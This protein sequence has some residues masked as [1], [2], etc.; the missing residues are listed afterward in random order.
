MD[1]A[2]RQAHTPLADHLLVT[3]GHFADEAVSVRLFRD[4]L[5]APAVRLLAAAGDVLGNSSGEQQVRLH[6]IANLRT[7]VLL[8]DYADVIAI[9]CQPA[10]GGRIEANDELSQRRLSRAA[11]ADDGDQLAGLDVDRDV[12]QDI[13][14]LIAIVAEVNSVETNVALQFR[15]GHARSQ[16]L[17]LLFRIEVEYVP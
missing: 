6:H 8:V 17:G 9:D 14:R 16:I 10:V 4:V 12:L 1:L 13:R 3:Q 11:A 7:V 5:D 15:Y 2:A